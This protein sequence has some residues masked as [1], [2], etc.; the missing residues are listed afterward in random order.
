MQPGSF[1]DLVNLMDLRLDSNSFTVIHDNVFLGLQSLKWLFLY[2]NTLTDIKK[3]AFRNMMNIEDID[4]S[5]NRLST[6]SEDIFC[7][8][9]YLLEHPSKLTLRLAKNSF[10]CTDNMCWLKEG[11]QKG[12]MQVDTFRSL[13]CVNFPNVTFGDVELDCSNRGIF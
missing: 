1:S 10:V 9:N 13:K 3:G 12:W 6:L 8:S 11:E 7:T 4:L 2:N 5:M